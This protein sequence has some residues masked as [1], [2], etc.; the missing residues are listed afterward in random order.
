MAVRVVVAKEVAVKV[1]AARIA[2]PGPTPSPGPAS[3]QRPS[4]PHRPTNQNPPL[5]SLPR[6]VLPKLKH[7]IPNLLWLTNWQAA[8]PR[9]EPAFRPARPDLD[10]TA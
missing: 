8:N 1:V 5:Q 3:P 9:R 4:P 7:P 10:A 2:L 6:L